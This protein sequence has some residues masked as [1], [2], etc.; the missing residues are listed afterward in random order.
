MLQS[1]I[2]DNDKWD[3]VSARKYMKERDIVPIKN[4]HKTEKHLRYRIRNPDYFSRFFSVKKKN[5][6]IYIIGK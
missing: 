3:V 2:F 4:V 1:V 5:G 6:V